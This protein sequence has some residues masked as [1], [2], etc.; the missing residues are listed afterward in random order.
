MVRASL[1]FTV[2][3]A[4]EFGVVL[5]QKRIDVRDVLDQ[6]IRVAWEGSVG[7]HVAQ[8]LGKPRGEFAVPVPLKDLGQLLSGKVIQRA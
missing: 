6:A 8:P 4:A 1:S 2:S 5:D 7:A 3:V